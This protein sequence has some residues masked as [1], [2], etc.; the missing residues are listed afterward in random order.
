[1]WTYDYDLET[2]AATNKRKFCE[3][4]PEDGLPDGATVD[5]DGCVWSTGVYKSKIHRFDPAGKLMQS[6]DM[7]VVCVTSV[8]FGGPKFDRLY[9]TSMV[10]APVPGVVETGPLAGSLFVIDGL[11]IKGLP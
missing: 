8:R 11:G 1:M 2:G 3:F 4:G 7:P 9:A 6:I 10:R 5:A